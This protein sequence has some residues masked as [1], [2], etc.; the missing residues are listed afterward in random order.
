MLKEKA[1][2]LGYLVAFF[3]AYFIHL[4]EVIDVINNVLFVRAGVKRR[5]GYILDSD[6]DGL[7]DYF[8]EALAAGD[9]GD[10]FAHLGDIHPDDDFDNDGTPN[11]AEEGNAAEPLPGGPYAPPAALDAGVLNCA[12]DAL[13]TDPGAAPAADL[14]VHTPLR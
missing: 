4:N 3:S 7:D 6:R 14:V 5:V 12:L 1:A 10:G 13:S 9:P 8:E 2:G 11:A